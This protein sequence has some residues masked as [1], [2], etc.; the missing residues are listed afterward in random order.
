MNTEFYNKYYIIC[1]E[2][3]ITDAWSDGPHPE[4]NTE[5]AICINDKGGYQLRLTINGEQTEE[6][7]FLCTIEGVPLYKWDG[8]QVIPRTEAEIEAD[9]AAI[10]PLP[11]SPIEQLRADMDFMSI[12]L[13]VKL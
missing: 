2:G 11:P 10:P 13:G 5:N 1:S 12:M 6:N 8:S 4:K 9:R 7:P 3:V